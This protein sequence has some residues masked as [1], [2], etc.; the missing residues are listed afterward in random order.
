VQDL[1]EDLAGEKMLH[2]SCTE[3]DMAGPG[4]FRPFSLDEL[5]TLIDRLAAAPTVS[6]RGRGT[7]GHHAWI[8]VIDRGFV[9][10]AY[11]GEETNEQG[12]IDFELYG[13]YPPGEELARQDPYA[14]KGLMGE[15]TTRC[16][17]D[18]LSLLDQSQPLVDFIREQ[19]LNASVV[20]QKR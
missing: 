10:H 8:S 2:A 19:A 20:G 6:S 4:D 12:R 16:L 9:L 5:G 13:A 1:R 17:K 18:A 3:F 14:G 15:M 7:S 11:F